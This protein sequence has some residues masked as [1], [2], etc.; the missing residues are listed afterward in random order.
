MAKPYSNVYRVTTMN[1]QKVLVHVCSRRRIRRISSVAVTRMRSRASPISGALGWLA[2]P[3]LPHAPLW[4]LLA[5]A[6]VLSASASLPP[7]SLNGQATGGAACKCDAGWTGPTCGQLD[8]M[9]APPLAKQ[10]TS[11]AATTTS[12]AVANSTWGMTVL[13]PDS[14]GT[15]HGYMTEIANACPLGDY[16]EASQVVHMTAAYPLGPWTRKAVALPGFAHNPQAVMAP[17]G[18]ILL[19]H[20]GQQLPPGCLLDCRTPP[21]LPRPATCPKMSHAASVAVAD[22]FDGPWTRH[23]YILGASPTN[24]APFLCACAANCWRW[25]CGGGGDALRC[26]RALL[27][28]LSA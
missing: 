4:G 28:C 15:Y 3:G 23:S 17:N 12:N 26:C 1:T 24:P 7:C 8:L 5:L 14:D 27:L 10:V 2:M 6:A 25:R 18:S 22:G 13:G 11:L 9:A 21:L 19:F 20:I 16:G